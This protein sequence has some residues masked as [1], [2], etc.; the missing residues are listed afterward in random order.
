M[1]M[2]KFEYRNLLKQLNNKQRFIFYDVIHLEN[3]CT[4][5]HQYVY[6]LTRGVGTGKTFTLKFVIQELYYNYIIKMCLLT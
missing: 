5:T 2:E 4:L 1:M 6:F 3:N